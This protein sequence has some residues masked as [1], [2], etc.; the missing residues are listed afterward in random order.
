MTLSAYQIE[1]EAFEE[2]M[3]GP[4]E[5]PRDDFRADGWRELYNHAVLIR[6]YAQSYRDF[7][8][9]CAMLVSYEHDPHQLYVYRGMNIKLNADDPKTCA[10]QVTGYAATRFKPRAKSRPRK[11]TIRG[12]VVVGEAQTEE[13]LKVLDL[14]TLHPCKLCRMWFRFGDANIK[15]LDDTRIVTAL[16]PPHDKSIMQTFDQLVR[17]HGEGRM[18]YLDYLVTKYRD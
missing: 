14:S 18:R 8:V 13:H 1:R 5:A 15:M 17:V 11:V 2:G 3:L 9:G 4:F 16:P 10:E 7:R 12:L 6:E